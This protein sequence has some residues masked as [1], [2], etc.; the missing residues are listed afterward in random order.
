MIHAR[1]FSQVA[2]KQQVP[3]IVQSAVYLLAPT[4][5]KM[6]DGRSAQSALR[7]CA[8]IRGKDEQEWSTPKWIMTV[9]G[10]CIEGFKPDATIG[11]RNL[12]LMSLPV[13]TIGIDH[14]A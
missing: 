5:G 4:G 12:D 9:I 2:A 7:L 13:E 3:E 8:A 10:L 6:V 14:H 11:Q 1:T